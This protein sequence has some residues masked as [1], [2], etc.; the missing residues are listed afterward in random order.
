VHEYCNVQ[1]YGNVHQYANVDEDYNFGEFI[2]SVGMPIE[3]T[4][5]IL[6]AINE[7]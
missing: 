4:V 6:N 3:L 1:Q 7:R 2:F 5:D